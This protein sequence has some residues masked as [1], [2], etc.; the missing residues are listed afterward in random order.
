MAADR[1]TTEAIAELK[2]SM[3]RNQAERLSVFFR[4]R[5]GPVLRFQ[6][7]EKE[8]DRARMQSCTGLSQ[9][10]RTSPAPR[11]TSLASMTAVRTALARV[12]PAPTNRRAGE[13]RASQAAT[14]QEPGTVARQSG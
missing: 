5:Q 7:E 1:C 4:S 3:T 2:A 14:W 13:G 9:H 6:A 10:G 12:V 8:Q 11:V